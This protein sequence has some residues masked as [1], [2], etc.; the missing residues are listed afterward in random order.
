MFDTFWYDGAVSWVGPTLVWLFN[1]YNISQTKHIA[2]L[3]Y[4]NYDFNI[5]LR[6]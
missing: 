2:K 6:Y 5:I 4:L 3:T 1:K